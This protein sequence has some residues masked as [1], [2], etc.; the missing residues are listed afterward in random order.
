VL[1][2]DVGSSALKAAVRDPDLRMRVDVAGLRDGRGGDPAHVTINA[3][4]SSVEHA[5][6]PEGRPGAACA[7][8]SPPTAWSAAARC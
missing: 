5:R 3:T 4:D 8:T 7:R 1:S 2:L 6:L